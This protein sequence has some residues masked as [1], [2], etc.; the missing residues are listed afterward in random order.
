MESRLSLGIS[1]VNFFSLIA[2]YNNLKKQSLSGEVKDLHEKNRQLELRILAL[3]SHKSS[4]HSYFH[5]PER[6]EVTLIAPHE[7]EDGE[8]EV[9]V[10]A[11]LA[12]AK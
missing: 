4:H 10:I 5:P 8:D 11:M 2:A 12:S 9:D 3:E 1:V 7:Q 6:S